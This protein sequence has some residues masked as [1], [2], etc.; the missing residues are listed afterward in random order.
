MHR[1]RSTFVWGLLGLAVAAC[2]NAS[3]SPAPRR[4]APPPIK[5][6]AAVVLPSQPAPTHVAAPA[7]DSPLTAAE[8]A[9]IRKT[10]HLECMVACEKELGLRK[11]KDDRKLGRMLCKD[12]CAIDGKKVTSDRSLRRCK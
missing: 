1:I 5:A 4:D 7:E 12:D 11:T 9:S 2:N 3:A 8:C 6:A 10:V